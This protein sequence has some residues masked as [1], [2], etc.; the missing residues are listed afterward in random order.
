[1]VTIA[2]GRGLR[3]AARTRFLTRCLS[4][5]FVKDA[6]ELRFVR[7]NVAGERLL[8]VSWSELIGKSDYDLFPREQADFFV[9]KD[10][11]VLERGELVD[12]AE[13]PIET[14]HRGQRILHTRKIPL[15]GADGRARYLVGISEDITERKRAE[16]QLEDRFAAEQRAHGEAEAARERI[17]QLLALSDVALAHHGLEVLLDE[18][19]GRL[20]EFLGVDTAA[21]LLVNDDGSTLTA[22]AAKGLEEEVEQGFTIP[23]G[24]GFAGRVAAERRPVVIDDLERAVVV[25]PLLREKGVCSL[26]GVPLVVEETTLGVLHVGSLTRRQFGESA[27]AAR[28]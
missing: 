26:L 25:N 23:L 22:R 2:G 17:S 18:L 15:L 1:M 3:R 5:V 19:L 20:R 16:A 7:L 4:M 14:R 28:G 27:A 12:I 8:G 24:A 11:E 9:A 6:G 10:R 13:E 21:I